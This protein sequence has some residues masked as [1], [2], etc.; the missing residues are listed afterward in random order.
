MPPKTT[1]RRPSTLT[2]P[3]PVEIRVERSFDA[4]REKVWRAFNDPKLL[5][6]WMGPA[7]YKMTTSHMDGHEGG[8]YRWAWDLGGGQ[9]L[10]IRGDIL[11]VDKPT[12][13]VTRE[14][15]DPYPGYTLNLLVFTESGDQT[16]ATVHITFP[17]AEA[18]DGALASGMAD[19]ME[20]G[21]TRLDALLK[22][23][24]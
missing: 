13:V 11:A 20:K 5:P 10:V 9:E 15:M 16:T 17:N 19:G 22:E 2:L 24:K 4:P 1:T 23:L 21:Y 18:R 6:K 14:F 3:S 12:R 7:Q 8:K